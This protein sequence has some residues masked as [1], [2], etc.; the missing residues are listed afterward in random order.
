MFIIFD[1]YII[2]LHN[3]VCITLIHGYTDKDM[4][5]VEVVVLYPVTKLCICTYIHIA[6][7]IYRPF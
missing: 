4:S 5:V 2:H 7:C 6:P 1:M 3:R